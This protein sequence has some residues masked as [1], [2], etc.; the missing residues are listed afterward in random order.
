MPNGL[1]KSFYFKKLAKD[2]TVPVWEG[3]TRPVKNK[4]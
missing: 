3:E 1:K 2:Q 4:H